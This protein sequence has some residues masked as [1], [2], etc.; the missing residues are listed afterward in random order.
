M[1][2]ILKRRCERGFLLIQVI[3]S[4]IAFN[5]VSWASEKNSTSE[6]VFRISCLFYN[7]ERNKQ[8]SPH[9]FSGPRVT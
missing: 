7:T 1:E 3:Y 2:K 4:V 9:V 5:K 6:T 8:I